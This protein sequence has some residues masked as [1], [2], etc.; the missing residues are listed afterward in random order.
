M[1]AERQRGMMAYRLHVV[2]PDAADLVANAAG[3]I[4]DRVM[5]GW[6]A[7]VALVDAAEAR[8][9]QILGAELV[10]TDWG[11]ADSDQE[12]CVLAIDSGLYAD[13]VRGEVFPFPPGQADVLVWGQSPNSSN[14]VRHRLSVAGHA[15]K[16]LAIAAAGV[17][18]PSVGWTEDF[19]APNATTGVISLRA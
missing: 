18:V 14:A 8:P 11:A 19:A 7:T 16:V 9:L 10:D 3:L 13:A 4:V 1:S 12:R 6:R 2:A 5:A 17:S 15:F